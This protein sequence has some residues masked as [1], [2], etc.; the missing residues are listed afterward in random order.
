M[1]C[2]WFQRPTSRLRGTFRATS[3]A[4]R[5]GSREIRRLDAKSFVLPWAR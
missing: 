5:A 3:A 2:R 1:K 4:A